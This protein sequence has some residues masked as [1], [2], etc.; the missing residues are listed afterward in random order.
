MQ[1][2]DEQGQKEEEHRL[3]EV[4]DEP[5]PI[6]ISDED[7]VGDE[8]VGKAIEPGM[9]QAVIEK[10]EYEDGA[11]R[12]PPIEAPQEVQEGKNHAD[13]IASEKELF[14]YER[15]DDLE[16]ACKGEVVEPGRHKSGVNRVVLMPET[17]LSAVVLGQHHGVFEMG[18][19]ILGGEI[20]EKPDRDEA[21]AGTQG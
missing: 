11:E 20:G 2:I 15:G 21:Q 5:V 7:Q 10:G 18:G 13:D 4:K 16:Q 19:A 12:G 6:E 9:E 3:P 17:A 14:G 1:E 8:A